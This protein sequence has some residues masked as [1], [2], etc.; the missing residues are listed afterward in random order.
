MCD[1][2]LCYCWHPRESFGFFTKTITIPI[3]QSIHPIQEIAPVRAFDRLVSQIDSVRI[4]EISKLGRRVI[5]SFHICRNNDMLVFQS[6]DC[7]EDVCHKHICHMECEIL[8]DHSTHSYQSFC[9]FVTLI[10]EYNSSTASSYA[11]CL[12]YQS[13]FIAQNVT[14]TNANSGKCCL[15]RKRK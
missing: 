10:R 14:R 12:E 3:H 5:R 13:R 4:C 7:M 8:L 6:F 11:Y 2:R 1:I 15:W 9:A